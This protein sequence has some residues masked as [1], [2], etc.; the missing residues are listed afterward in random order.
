MKLILL[1]KYCQRF[2]GKNAGIY[3]SDFVIS[4]KCQLPQLD[5]STPRQAR[6]PRLSNHVISTLLDDHWVV[7]LI[8]LVEMSFVRVLI[9]NC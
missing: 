9:L 8:E 1:K 2:Y 6:C 7:K 5:T 4:G 3:G